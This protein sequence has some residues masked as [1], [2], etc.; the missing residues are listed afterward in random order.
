MALVSV[1]GSGN[2]FVQVGNQIYNNQ[3]GGNWA[4][5]NYPYPYARS[6][7]APA[8]YRMPMA[9]MT[10]AS[11][12]GMP[13]YSAMPQF[14]VNL[15]ALGGN[16]MPNFGDLMNT[17][18]S[19]DTSLGS[20]GQLIS[21]NDKMLNGGNTTAVTGSNGAAQGSGNW[22]SSMQAMFQ[23]IVGA[24]DGTGNTGTG[25]I[26]NGMVGNGPLTEGLSEILNLGGDKVNKQQVAQALFTAAG[27]LEPES[28]AALQIQQGVATL[29]DRNKPQ[30]DDATTLATALVA[31]LSNLEPE[32]KDAVTLGQALGTLDQNKTNQ[33]T[34]GDTQVKQSIET[35]SLD[36]KLD[37]LQ[38][39]LSA[40]NNN[41]GVTATQTTQVDANTTRPKAPNV[42]TFT[43]ARQDN[44]VTTA[45][46]V[47]TPVVTTNTNGTV[48]TAATTTP[49]VTTN[50]NATVTTAATTTPAVTTNTNATVT[51]AAT[52]TPVVNNNTNATVTT[53]ATTTPTVTTTNPPQAQPAVT[54]PPATTTIENNRLIVGRD[55]ITDVQ[56]QRTQPQT[57]RLETIK[58]HVRQ[59][60]ANRGVQVT[61]LTGADAVLVYNTVFG[62]NEAVNTTSISKAEQSLNN[63]YQAIDRQALTAQV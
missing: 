4:F 49:V 5:G 27:N 35:M 3:S 28:P 50:T 12:W 30:A 6:S 44:T 10:Y 58:N 16:R 14:P 43:A 22:M 18:S 37:L 45:A 2:G 36:Q 31:A 32:S 8:G 42:N 59:V 40:R 21:S 47:K 11:P 48:T 29:D 55:L 52:T 17:Q 9:G 57:N 51:T 24:L 33:T 26:L 38:E 56:A 7:V 61:E 20:L 41:A 46:A 54:Q 60:A 63:L 53:A 25:N 23:D 15:A 39:L 34:Q 62:R 13:Q 19:I 1:Q